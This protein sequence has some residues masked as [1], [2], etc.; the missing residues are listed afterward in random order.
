MYRCVVYS[1][2]SPL[3]EYEVESMSAAKAAE[4]YGRK[5]EGEMV[6]VMRKKTYEL[7]SVVAWVWK[8]GDRREGFYVR[9]HIPKDWR[10]PRLKYWWGE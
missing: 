4:M 7:L 9:G 2:E 1:A 6:V 5:E 8:C 3:R 10:H